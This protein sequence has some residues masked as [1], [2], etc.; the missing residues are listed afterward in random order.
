[1]NLFSKKLILLSGPR[2]GS[3]FLTGLLSSHK[4]IYMF[5]EL[6]NISLL[7]RD[8]LK[9]VA[10]SSKQFLKD[11]LGSRNDKVVG[12]KLFY[13]H[14]KTLFIDDVSWVK[15]QLQNKRI[16]NGLSDYLDLISN[17]SFV[18]DL[19]ISYEETLDYLAQ[20]KSFYVIHL[21][22]NNRLDSLLSLKNAFYTDQWVLIGHSTH[23]YEP[24]K[25][26]VEECTEH[27]TEIEKSENY[28]NDLFRSHKL[29]E[30]EYKELETNRDLVLSKIMSFLDLKHQNL[31]TC[32][33]KQKNQPNSILIENFDE[34]KR[35]YQ[36]TKWEKYFR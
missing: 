5:N 18:N 8:D 4:D 35:E 19:T 24:I 9:R 10:Q 16:F 25:L 2:T 12:F 27:F 21:K 7:N 14:L 3:T 22:R 29:L 13:D 31:N 1:M 28:F 17:D 26:S 36:N 6:F 11:K 30:V 15:E 20:D 23:S 33:S 32:F 34:L